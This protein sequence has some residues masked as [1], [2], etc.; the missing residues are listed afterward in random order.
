M[1]GIASL[2]L[3]E[4][5]RKG[6][7]FLPTLPRPLNTPSRPLRAVYTARPFNER[8]PM[9]I[10]VCGAAGEVTGSCYLVE[11][12][13]AKF[14]VDFGMFQGSQMASEQN[15]APLPV[16]TDLLDC[17][18][19][20]HAHLDH[21]GRLPLLAKNGFGGRVH[22]TPPTLDVAEILL[23]DSAHIQSS[24][25]RWINK[26]RRRRGQPLIEP[27]YTKEHVDQIFQT[28]SPIR[29]EEP[30]EI[31]PGVSLRYLEAGHIIGSASAELTVEEG[32][33]KKVLL[34]SGDIGYWDRPI[35]RDPA[36]PEHA[37]IVFMESTYGGREHR[38]LDET[39]KEFNGIL[40]EASD[41]R[42]KILM[43]VFAVGRTQQ[44]FYHLAAAFRSGELQKFPVYLDSPLAQKATDLYMQHRCIYDEEMISLRQRQQFKKDL[45]TLHYSHTAD[46][47][48]ALNDI[49]GPALI[50]AGAGM[51]NGGRIVHH[52]KHNLESPRTAVVIVGYQARHTTGGALVHGAKKVRIFGQECEVNAKIH[53]LGGFSAHAGHSE[54][55]RWLGILEASRPRLVV[56]HGEPDS[57]EALGSAAKERFGLE[58]EYPEL[59]ASF[60][61]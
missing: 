9:K 25:I 58:P 8:N 16:A 39:V 21:A 28:F 22:G 18:V 44:I 2:G 3:K 34:F 29:Y 49:N 53:T 54:L 48:R 52:L 27:L 56:M 38:S 32:G 61:V 55:L 59:G 19:L 13:R 36:P 47:S 11:T 23:E 40:K 17:V 37:D 12:D 6:V 42:H 41:K 20:T 15:E 24:S 14:L 26:R 1:P 60:E 50:M 43:P 10:T 46:E 7:G 35:L 51:C 33:A 45:S 30:T 5:F 31:A 57:R 4:P